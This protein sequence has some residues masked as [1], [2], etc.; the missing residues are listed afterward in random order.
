MERLLIIL[1]VLVCV[2]A[3][4]AVA[5]MSVRGRRPP[6]RMGGD[7]DADDERLLLGSVGTP[8]SPI[9]RSAQVLDTQVLELEPVEASTDMEAPRPVEGPR[10]GRPE[11]AR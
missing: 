3:G 1:A 6:L 2:A 8:D 5:A 10:P 7:L 11:G 9:D 4:L